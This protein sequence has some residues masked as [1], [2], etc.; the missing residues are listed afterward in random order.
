[1][2]YRQELF[3]Q[4]TPYLQWLKERDIIPNKEYQDTGKPIAVFPFSSCMDSVEQ[5]LGGRADKGRNYLFI[6]ADGRLQEGAAALIAE[7]LSENAEIMLVYADEDYYGTL[8]ELYQIEEREFDETTIGKFRESGNGLFRGEPWLKPDFAPDTLES[9][10]YVGNIFAVSGQII[11]E[12]TELFGGEIS[13]CALVRA[14]SHRVTARN[15]AAHGAD[16]FV[17]IPKVLYTN[18]RLSKKDELDGFVSEAFDK[19]DIVRIG[20]ASAKLGKLSVIIPSKDNPQVLKRCVETFEQCVRDV[21]YELII[22]DNGSTDNNCM[23]IKAFLEERGAKYLYDKAE[24]NFSRMC[25]IGAKAA[26]G[27]YLLFLNDDIEVRQ[28]GGWWLLKMM[29]YA[30]MEHIGAVGMKLRY[31]DSGLIQHAGITNMGIGPA[32]KLGGMP[33]KGNLYH[34]HNLADYN[35]LAVTAA[36]M[37]VSRTKFERAGG[38]DEELAVAY[39]D[40]ELCFRLYGMGFYNVQVN[41]AFLI[42]HESLSR[43]QDTTPEKR[44]RLLREKQKLYE[45]HAWAMTKTG[46]YDPFYSQNLVQWEK[47]AAYHVNY[48]YPCDRTVELEPLTEEGKKTLLKWFML[49]HIRQHLKRINVRVANCYRKL[50]G[51]NRHMFHID[52][53]AQEDG[54]VTITGWH[55]LRRRDNTRLA[56]TLVIFGPAWKKYEVQLS[57]KL[58]RDVESLFA[59]DRRT[60]NTAL[61]GICLKFDAAHLPKGHYSAGIIVQRGRKR[62]FVHL[63]ASFEIT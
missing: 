10:F 63:K 33:D 3:A 56:K 26:D 21:D 47:D 12:M 7:K 5:V 29:R 61:S 8:A 45:K 35:M 52:Q 9:F 27:D 54:I 34:G 17:H 6:N 19:C 37:M 55:V 51:E 59:Q 49:D 32:H 39:N 24:F 44:E 28:D 53:I 50:I 13:L 16:S 36:C 40:V 58:R 38:F 25:N 41:S 11:E 46:G 42:H 14:I 23:C 18:N 2:D 20:G 4:C 30:A 62:R 43:G 22:V 57:P 60:K 15:D 1:M 31:P 48:L